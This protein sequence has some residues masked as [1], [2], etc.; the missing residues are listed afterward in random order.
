MARYPYAKAIEKTRAEIKN[1]TATIK[2]S[3]STI[4][5]RRKKRRRIG[6]EMRE[7]LA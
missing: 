6:V 2:K 5:F 4:V 1:F 3:T 7:N